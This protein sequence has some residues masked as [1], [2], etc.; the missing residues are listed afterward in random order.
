MNGL[1]L[2]FEEKYGIFLLSWYTE[3]PIVLLISSRVVRSL[4]LIW[5][6]GTRSSNELLSLELKVG[7]QGS[8]PINDHQGDKLQCSLTGCAIMDS[9]RLMLPT[10]HFLAMSTAAWANSRLY[11]M[12]CCPTFSS[13]GLWWTKTKQWRHIHISTMAS[14]ITGNFTVC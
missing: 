10:R 12:V 8:S 1:S 3:F 13:S 14:H 6:S 7:H 5:R 11:S 2:I 9:N 4:Q